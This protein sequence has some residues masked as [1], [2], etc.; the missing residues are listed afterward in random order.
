VQD[1][2]CLHRLASN[3]HLAKSLPTRKEALILVRK[4]IGATATVG[5]E[6]TPSKSLPIRKEALILVRKKCHEAMPRV[7]PPPPPARPGW[8]Y[9]RGQRGGGVG[10]RR[11]GAAM[12]VQRLTWGFMP[13]SESARPELRNQVSDR[14]TH[15]TTPN[16]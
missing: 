7:P 13:E 15:P 2:W 1:D 6:L 10:G 12:R 8:R 14:S 5:L 11:G 4:M 3:R 9:A 16:I